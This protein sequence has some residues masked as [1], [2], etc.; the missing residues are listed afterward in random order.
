MIREINDKWK[1]EPRNREPARLLGIFCGRR[2]QRLSRGQ[3]QH[4]KTA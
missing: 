3:I 1:T 4:P 2:S